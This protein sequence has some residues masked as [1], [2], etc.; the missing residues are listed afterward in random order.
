MADVGR[1]KRRLRR[2]VEKRLRLE[3]DSDKSEPVVSLLDSQPLLE[4]SQ[5]LLK[6]PKP[7]LDCTNNTETQNSPQCSELSESSELSECPD[8]SY[9]SDLYESSFLD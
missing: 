6:P 7:A 2:A 4:P 5:P 9:S 3:S 8:C 1:R